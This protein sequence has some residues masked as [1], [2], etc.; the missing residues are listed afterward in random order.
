[1]AFHSGNGS[2]L[3]IGVAT[4]NC[5]MTR[6]RQGARLAENTH[7]GTSSTNF[8]AVVKDHSW[9]ASVPFDDTNIPD[10][11]FGLVEGAKVTLV[12]NAGGS[13]KTVTLTNTSVESVEYI[14]DNA[15]DIIRAEVSGRGGSLTRMTT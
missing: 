6:W 12:F 10:T 1:M 14:C 15:G 7:S 2:L 13:G 8:E 5:R 11:D 3:T 4:L 9:S